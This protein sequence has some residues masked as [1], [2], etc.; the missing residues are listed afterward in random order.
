MKTIK[1]K[2]K[3]VF[4]TFFLS[5]SVVNAGEIYKIP[6][7]DGTFLYTDKM[8]KYDKKIGVLSK[9]SGVI[10]PFSEEDYN[11]DIKDPN[12]NEILNA[13][14]RKSTDGDQR[15]SNDILVSK[16][17]NLEELDKIKKYDLEQLQRAISTDTNIIETLTIQKESILKE[18]NGKMNEKSSQELKRVEN[19]IKNASVNKER[20]EKMLKEKEQGYNKDRESLVKMLKEPSQKQ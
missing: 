2:N 20:N 8:P 9:T 17:S 12:S 1:I 6:Q 16:Y 4:S 3:I 10:K 5:F 19:G 11:Q 13:E 15:A 14:K 7:P 18:S